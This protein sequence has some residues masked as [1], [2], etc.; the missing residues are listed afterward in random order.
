MTNGWDKGADFEYVFRVLERMISEPINPKRYRQK[1]NLAY[2]VICLTQL[3]NG[4]RISEAIEFVKEAIR[5]KK[6]KMEI[7]VRKHKRETYRTMILPNAV[8]KNHLSII[9]FILEIPDE[10]LRARIED[11]IRRHLKINTHTLRYAFITHLS[12]KGYTPQIIAAITG[13]KNLNY[14]LKYTQ[15]KAGELVL[16]TLED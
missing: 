11:W 15:K 2:A 16:E 13:H 4:S 10:K 14:V 1:T 7:R 6:R 3:R 9:R 5:T 8:N 12:R